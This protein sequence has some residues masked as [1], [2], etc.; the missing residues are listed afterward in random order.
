[1]ERYLWCENAVQLT[2]FSVLDIKWIITCDF[3]NMKPDTIIVLQTNV[4]AVE[5][6][7]REQLMSGSTLQKYGATL[8]LLITKEW[9]ENKTVT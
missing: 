2:L 7:S 4:S 8:L 3:R 1:M 9:Q 5:H 6:F